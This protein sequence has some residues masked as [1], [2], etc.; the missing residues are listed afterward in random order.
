MNS[1]IIWIIIGALSLGLNTLR[2]NQRSVFICV[3]TGAY[4][5]HK[6]TKCRG[7]KNCTHTIKEIS[8]KYAVDT[9]RKKPCGYCY[10]K[11]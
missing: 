11:N 2:V 7:M 6:D 9:L 3:S 8:I 10:P 1:K 4:A 5:Y